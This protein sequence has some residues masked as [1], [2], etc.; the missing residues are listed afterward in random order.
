G[1]R[2]SF[3]ELP[4][5]L[6]ARSFGPRRC[7]SYRARGPAFVPQKGGS[8]IPG[9]RTDHVVEGI[10]H[11]GDMTELTI[12]QGVIHQGRRYRVCGVDP[13]SMAGRCVYLQDCEDGETVKVPVSEVVSDDEEAQPRAAPRAA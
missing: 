5:Y 6:R 10:V 12:G 9:L 2:T 11:C 8:G 7:D 3:G 4:G 1:G 13:M